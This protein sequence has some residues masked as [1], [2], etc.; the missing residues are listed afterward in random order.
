M[1]QAKERMGIM[2]SAEEGRRKK[3]LEDRERDRI[4]QQRRK[5]V[6]QKEGEGTRRKGETKKGE[7]ENEVAK[8][9]EPKV[10]KVQGVTVKEVKVKEV[11]PGR[12]L[13][14]PVQIEGEEMLLLVDT[15][16]SN[17]LL[18]YGQYLQ[19]PRERRSE[20]EPVGLEL[21]Q[22]DGAGVRIR[23]CADVEF[24]IGGCNLRV[25]VIVSDVK[26]GI[27]GMDVLERIKAIIDFGRCQL[28]TEEGIV[29]LLS[30]K[31]EKLRVRV[32]ASRDV[33]IPAKHQVCMPAD[34]S[35]ST[36]DGLGLV[37]PLEGLESSS[38][39][40]KGLMVGRGVVSPGDGVV[41]ISVI[42][43]SDKPYTVKRGTVLAKMV[44]VGEEDVCGKGVGREATNGELPEYLEELAEK[45]TEGMV[46]ED[47]EKV[48]ALLIK[49]QDVFSSGEYDIGRTTLV[50][51]SID[52]GDARP[53]RQPL[54]RSGPVQRDETE[55]QV[56]ELLAKGMISPSDSPWSSPVVLVTKKDGTKRMCLDYRGLNDVTVK[57][58]Y[59][60]PR[61][62]DSLDA[63]GGARYFVALDL[64]AGYW[65]ILMDAAARDKSAFST[66]SG[67]YAWNV[68]PF[69]LCNAP[70]TFERLMENVL[71]GLRWETLLV[72]LDDVIVFGRTIQQTVDRLEVVLE[73]FRGAGLKLKPS[74]CHLFKK[75]VKYLG[76]VV[77]EKGIHTDPEKISAVQD[78]P[79]PRTPTQVRSFLGLASYYRRFIKGFA[80]IAAPLHRLTETK[81]GDKFEWVE[82]C[83]QA[84]ATLKEALISA[85]ILGYPRAV[86]Q[87]VLDTDASNFAIGGVLSQE[88]DG[89]ERVIAYGSKALSKPERNYCVTRRELLAVVVFLKKYRH[90]LTGTLAK[91]RTDHG[92]LRW[93]K[94]FKN[95]E[96]QLARWMEVLSSFNLLIEYRA[97]LRH[98]N[99]DGLSRI[100]CKQCGR[101]EA[102]RIAEVERD[103]LEEWEEMKFV[104]RGDEVVEERRVKC[105]MGCQTE[106]LNEGV[107][108]RKVACNMG[109]QTEVQRESVDTEGG[110]WDVVTVVLPEEVPEGRQHDCLAVRQ[111]GIEPTVTLADIRK[112]QM[113]D[114]TIAFLL[115]KKE[116][117]GERPTSEEVSGLSSRA[118]THSGLWEVLAVK[119]GVLA[120][121]WE[122][123]CGREVKW[124]V[125]LPKGLHETVLDELHSSRSAGHLGRNK[126][127]PKV[128]ERYYWAGMDA[129]IRAYL[130]RCTGC[131]QKKNPQRK[132]R[133]PL[134]Q[135]RVGAPLERIAIDVLGPLP[136]THRG[137]KYILV[138]GDY[139]TK[140]ME[141]YAIEDQQAE[142]VAEK[143]VCEFVCRFG[144]PAELHSDQ[145]RNFESLVFQEMCRLLGISKTR[146]TPYHPCS[147]GMVERY[148]R[149]I[150]DAVSLM[151]QPHERQRDWDEYLPYVGLAYRASEQATTGETPNMMMLGREVR[152]PV[153]LVVGGVP[154][155]K[156]CDT[157]YAEE[158]RERIRVSHERARHALGMNMRR[159]KRNYDRR[160]F[161]P[162]YNVGQFVWLHRPARQ[163]RLS[164]KLMLPWDGPYLV[165]TALSDVTFRV[166][167]SSRSKPM[168]V[169]ANRLKLYEGPELVAW[170]YQAPEVLEESVLQGIEGSGDD[171]EGVKGVGEEVKAQK[172]GVGIDG[173]EKAGDQSKKVVGILES[174]PLSSD[175]TEKDGKEND[176][177]DDQKG[178][179]EDWESAEEGPRRS[180]RQGR[181][182]PERYR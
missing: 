17:T 64:A 63:L 37:E 2:Q 88:Q 81:G 99:A 56:K 14:A 55:R 3:E 176:R 107:G 12:D 114:E 167:K 129:D 157:F 172:E 82:E 75:E 24:K 122:S 46:E 105:D 23:G 8:D 175:E 123:D 119:E 80:D 86:G 100:P 51:H 85:P 11:K 39:F 97:G 87:F 6:E 45:S 38:L 130:R 124:L 108:E 117:G 93:L 182:K 59:P 112:A 116:A 66:A 170:V 5:L 49:Y 50:K 158:L 152:L 168:V 74:K 125:V 29:H 92:S 84:F 140:W 19:I 1:L 89:V 163:P 61:I 136:E 161:G 128:S 101:N 153:D 160:K 32:C 30:R 159:Q 73:R 21:N 171:V 48:M 166:Q 113:E 65:Q 60:L 147:D 76:H 173:I 169:H 121:R 138:V 54:R 177:K 13:Y 174:N 131:A 134:K 91:V 52:T 162:M 144:A 40:G 149:T 20:L 145:G 62:D 44:R 47:R 33:T 71:S 53:I 133:A 127:K 35:G 109:C 96:G 67:L 132:H 151:I 104:A 79:A 137:N 69:G 22:A 4:E 181:R 98:Q 155:E 42:N 156:E 27:L 43:A 58:A 106:E 115:K 118:K 7:L 142:T 68:L 165:V 164:K 103:E 34:V 72:Y 126:V 120:R 15:G 41:P 95:P 102:K 25:P 18:T 111:I 180:R 9:G 78:W 28:G 94:N 16:S 135:H 57:D 150:V 148:N 179:E 141:A 83:A 90:Y 31:G 70:A 10:I 26:C 110:G 178:E 77:S 139:W 154:D 36:R 146:T 143:L